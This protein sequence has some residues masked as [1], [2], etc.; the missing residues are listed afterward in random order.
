MAILAP[1]VTKI[2]IISLKTGKIPNEWERV[3]V[4]P[5][6][7]EK[8]ISSCSNL[9]PISLTNILMRLFERCA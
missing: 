8:L 3:E 2:F 6:P 9:R 4:I 7:K 1:V 5:S